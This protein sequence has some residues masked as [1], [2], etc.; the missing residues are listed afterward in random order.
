MCQ[1]KY[2]LDWAKYKEVVPYKF[3]PEIIYKQYLLCIKS[4]NPWQCNNIS[5]E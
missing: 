2:G 1:E 3:I 5:L 4:V